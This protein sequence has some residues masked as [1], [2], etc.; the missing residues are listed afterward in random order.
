M[1]GYTL[2]MTELRVLITAEDPLARAGLAT[3]LAARPDCAVV[4]QVTPA[5]LAGMLD[6]YR[7][8]VIVWD[9]GWEA[10]PGAMSALRVA[11]DA[12]AEYGP[13]APPVAVLLPDEAIAA[14]A[15]TAGVRGLLPRAIEVERLVAALHGIAQQLAVIDPTFASSLIPDSFSPLDGQPLAED[16]TP[17]EAEV[18]QLLAEG[19]AN[20][21]IALKLG[22]SEHTVKFHINALMG[23][24][25]A[26]SRTDAVVRAARR[27][28]LIL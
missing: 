14:E 2:N 28:L 11:L 12:L 15:W 21:A 24:L 13:A 8:D 3:L 27:G 17:R 6:I 5:D 7:P 16:L 25:G 9:S 23:K 4:G 19:L 1:Q 22:I 20:K 18:L 10:A 26:Q